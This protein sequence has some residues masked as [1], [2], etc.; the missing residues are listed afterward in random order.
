MKKIIFLSVL[1]LLMLTACTSQPSNQTTKVS[2][3]KTS[4]T[5][6]QTSSTSS[7][8][9][10]TMTE[11]IN[12]QALAKQDY[13]SVIGTWKNSEGHT[14][15]FTEKGL[16]TERFNFSG[17]S[18]TDYGTASSTVSIN[19]SPGGFLLEFIPAGVALPDFTDSESGQVYKDLSEHS[20][21]RLWLGQSLISRASKGNFYYKVNE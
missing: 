3:S 15:S 16:V 4:Q 17:A 9:E 18:M 13:S 20:K 5:S 12:P 21:N 8:S 1:A 2:D 7:K 6:T 14:L 11:K 10:V 19:E